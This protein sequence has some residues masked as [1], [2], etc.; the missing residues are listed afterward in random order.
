MV[1]PSHKGGRSPR[2]SDK[3]ERSSEVASRRRRIPRSPNRASKRSR[4][5]RPSP[6][7][8][9]NEGRSERGRHL[10]KRRRSPS[11]PSSSPPSSETPPS[12]SSTGSSYKARSSRKRKG[13]YQAWKRAKKLETFK[14]GRKNITFLSYDGSYGQ[15]DK[16]W[17]LFNNLMRH[18]VG[19]ISQRY[20]SYAMLQ[21]IFKRVQGN[22]GQV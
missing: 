11:P 9:L 12:S 17:S 1:E 15:T 22:G 3:E 6:D 4:R 20:P 8:F 21:C 2:D 18:L 7:S 14:E 19:S 16:S 5:P 10:Q 13:Y